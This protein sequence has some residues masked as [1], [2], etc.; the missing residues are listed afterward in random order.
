MFWL[1]STKKILN[2]F[3]SFAS[4]VVEQITAWLRF[5]AFI[6]SMLKWPFIYVTN[7]EVQKNLQKYIGY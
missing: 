7:L 4:Q 2:N 5:K 1:I 3:W 6:F